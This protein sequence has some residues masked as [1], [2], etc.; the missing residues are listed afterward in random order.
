VL[1]TNIS[2]VWVGNPGSR[3]AKMLLY[4]M[5]YQPSSIMSLVAAV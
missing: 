3:G 5:Y 1:L 4:T 2:R